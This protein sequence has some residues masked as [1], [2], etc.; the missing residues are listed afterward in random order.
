[1]AEDTG[2]PAELLVLES[3]D[4]DARRRFLDVHRQLAALRE[5]GVLRTRSA[6]P[7]DGQVVAVRDPVE[8]DGLER[9]AGPLD[10]RVV[11]WIG[12]V[13]GPAILG[14]GDL[15]KGLLRPEDVALTASGAPILAPRGGAT[16]RLPREVTARL[17]PEA[18]TGTTAASALYGLGALLWTL[19]TGR[20]WQRTAG[21]APPPAPGVIRPGLPSQLDAA[22]LT[23]LARD[24]GR[25]PG[26]LALLHEIAASSTDLRRLARPNPATL[27]VVTTR[28]AQAGPPPDP[29]ALVLVPARAVAGLD[30]AQRSL[31]AGL[32]ALPDAVVEDLAARNLPVVVEGT[33]GA[34][35]ARRRAAE[36]AA[37]TGLP[38]DWGSR[39]GLPG[40][41]PL[42]AGAAGALLSTAVG[43]ALALAGLVPG[44]VVALGAAVASLIGG[45]W[46]GRVM[47]GARAN[48]SA[49]RLATRQAR[50]LLRDHSAEGRLDAAFEALART[51]RA[52]ALAHLP[53]SVATDLR[54]AVRDIERRLLAI[55]EAARQDTGGVDAGLLRARLATL[56]GRAG[57]DPELLRER[58]RLARTVADLDAAEERRERI[59]AHQLAL[60][61]RL[62][63]IAA[64]VAGFDHDDEAALQRLVLLMREGA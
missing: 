49:G 60:V 18:S 46:A 56:Q 47:G 39:S 53:P 43:I 9:V 34:R 33:A 55:G 8:D 17:P 50:A 35:A 48:L 32:A 27:P 59:V 40:W 11:A 51:R 61:D 62:D 38:V 28:G 19:S 1:M 13:L 16:D 4:P 31:L 7:I 23:L 2:E 6:T 5:P 29:G 12:A 20:P 21:D 57:G 45:A 52:I 3:R 63:A 54:S 58:D 14:A 37:S 25:R 10:P 44:L 64:A 22:V 42:A 24:P 30:A 41:L 36:L 15:L 26:A